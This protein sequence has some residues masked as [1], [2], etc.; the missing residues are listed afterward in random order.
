MSETTH[1]TPS[2]VI[3]GQL[4]PAERAFIT[5]AVREDLVKPEITVEVGTW[6]GGG[7]TLHILRALQANGTGHLWGVE[8]SQDIYEKMLANIRLGA[9]DAAERFTPLFGFSTVVLPE[10]LATLAPDAKIDFVFLDGGDKPYEQI[11]EFRLLAPRLRTGGIL[12]A[13]D[14]RM[15]KGKWLGPYVA[16]LDNWESSVHDLSFA[17]IFRARK[18][19]AEPSPASLKAAERKLRS[20]QREPREL[21]AR[22][23]PSW[24]CG[25]VLRLLPASLSRQL[26]LGPQIL[27]HDR[28]A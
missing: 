15:R 28:P 12:M 3:D 1:A 24:F 21:A 14:A 25:F 20:L 10:W 18:I 22:F 7:S 6:L 11:E 8:A 2:T 4:N 26:T 13:H 27:E 9:P 17:G 23:L 19:K 16:E 5:K